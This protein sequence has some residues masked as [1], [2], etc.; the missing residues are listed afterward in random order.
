MKQTCEQKPEG[1]G[2]DFAG[3]DGRAPTRIG[4]AELPLL[5]VAAAFVEDSSAEFGNG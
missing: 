5:A 2:G 4:A 3:E 1:G